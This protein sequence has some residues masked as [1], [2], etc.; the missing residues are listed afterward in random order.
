MATGSAGAGGGGAACSGGGGACGAGGCNCAGSSAGWGGTTAG[1]GGAGGG[2]ARSSGGVKPRFGKRLLLEARETVGCDG[3]DENELEVP[4]FGST[5]EKVLV[6][7]GPEPL[8][9]KLLKLNDAVVGDAVTAPM[10]SGMT[11]IAKAAK[12]QA[13]ATKAAQ[14]AHRQ[15]SILGSPESRIREEA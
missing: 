9:A 13:P 3:S 5:L 10:R 11:N 2:S 7:S 1:G 14:G 8:L 4:L 15:L 6:R 12:E